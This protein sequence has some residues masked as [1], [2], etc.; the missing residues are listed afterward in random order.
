MSKINTPESVAHRALRF[1]NEDERSLDWLSTQT[2]IPAWEL[3]VI[4]FDSP[5]ELTINQLGRIAEAL[6]RPLTDL[7]VAA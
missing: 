5:T 7:V 2:G 4:L 1:V 3:E 6:G